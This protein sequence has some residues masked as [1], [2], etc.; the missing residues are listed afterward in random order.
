[1]QQQRESA[2]QSTENV[3]A[4]HTV[5]EAITPLTPHIP[6]QPGVSAPTAV[7]DQPS[8]QKRRLLPR[9]AQVTAALST[10]AL[11]LAFALPATAEPTAEASAAS[12]LQQLIN[13]AD[14]DTSSAPAIDEVSATA[15][16]DTVPNGFRSSP[17]AVVSYP[18]TDPVV[19]TDG[20]GYRSAPVAQFHAAQDF[21]A[22]EGTPIWAIASGTIS[23]AGFI[24]DACGFALEIE[25]EIDGKEVRS[26]Y[27]HMQYGSHTWSIG[28]PI[29]QGDLVGRV[30]N[31][32]LSFGAHLHLV[33][34]VEGEE[35]DPMVFLETY[36]QVSAK[37]L[38]SSATS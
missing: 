25:H 13:S 6:Q 9:I 32:G 21:G 22:A 19:L 33:I 20:F 7:D 34:Y 14:V 26:R 29:D 23:E 5:H 15:I 2:A 38:G 28:D 4:D 17:N 1:M 37:D 31:T 12:A 36:S 18:F 10:G 24:T 16:D 3:F 11:A 27:C 8:P 30:G 35:V